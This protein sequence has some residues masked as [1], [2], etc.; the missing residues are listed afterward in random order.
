MRPSTR[1]IGELDPNRSHSSEDEE[2]LELG[3][4]RDQEADLQQETVLR[5]SGSQECRTSLSP[6]STLP[7]SRAPSSDSQI[8]PSKRMSTVSELLR[9]LLLG[10]AWGLGQLLLGELFALLKSEFFP[11]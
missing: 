4:P 10:A 2:D 8:Y 11:N 6:A 5:S 1:T 9:K 7:T 3:L